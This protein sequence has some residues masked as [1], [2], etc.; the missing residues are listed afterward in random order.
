MRIRIARRPGSLALLVIIGLVIWVPGL[1]QTLGAPPKNPEA[2]K[3][4]RQWNGECIACH[5][6][7][8]VKFPPRPNMDLEKLADALMD[9]FL[10]E[11][12][13][14][15]GMAC[16]TCHGKSYVEY[17]HVK[18]AQEKI[19]DCDEC[20]AQL[21]FRVKAQFDKSVHAKN[22]SDRF[23]CSTCHDPHVDR[24]A[25]ELADP[26]KI[27]TQDNGKC[28]DCHDSDLKFAEYGGSL[29][30]KKARPDIDAIHEFL[31][32]AQRHWQAV[33]C[34]ECHTPV[35]THSKLDLSHEILD[36]ENAQRDCGTCHSKNTVLRTRLYRYVAQEETEKMGFLN[37]AVMG[38]VY[39]IGATRN[40]YLDRLA[41]WLIGLTAAGV[42]L[43]GLLRILAGLF[44]RGSN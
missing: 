19:L 32:N 24:V 41:L 18:G 27:L 30:K 26:Q 15:Q 35:S 31:P 9:P 17:P 33:R 1:T 23:T 6:E 8:A 16:K 36:R 28:L 34:V 21:A 4:V 2:Q 22:L 10:Y 7:Q 42:A 13:Q 40:V 37:S 29:P 11:K 3:M 38:D 12:S 20:H 39:V 25:R 43:H 5:T 44:R 14:H